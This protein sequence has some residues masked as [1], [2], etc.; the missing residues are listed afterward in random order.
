[1]KF[2]ALA[3]NGMKRTLRRRAYAIGKAEPI[4]VTVDTHNTGKYDDNILEEIIPK[5]FDLTPSGIISLLNLSY[6]IYAAACNYGHFTHDEMPWEQTKHTNQL[7]KAC[8]MTET[9]HSE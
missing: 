2:S 1:M 4:A 3:G 6:P 8:W 9:N 7:W 5:V